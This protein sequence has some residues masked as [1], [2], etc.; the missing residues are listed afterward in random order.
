[1]ALF[2]GAVEQ[3]RRIGVFLPPIRQFDLEDLFAFATLDQPVG[4]V[5]G[6]DL[7]IAAVQPTA[8]TAYPEFDH[9]DPRSKRTAPYRVLAAGGGPPLHQARA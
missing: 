3:L 6:E 7:A 4:Q 8:A 1:M 2:A 5:V 9:E